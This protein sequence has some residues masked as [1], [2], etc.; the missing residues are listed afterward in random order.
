[1]LYPKKCQ[2]GF[3][4][5]RLNGRLIHLTTI[6]TEPKVLWEFGLQKLKTCSFYHENLF[7]QKVK[8]ISTQV[9]NNFFSASDIMEAVRGCFVL[10]YECYLTTI[11]VG[12]LLVP[13]NSMFGLSHSASFA[14]QKGPTKGQMK[15]KN[16]HL[17]A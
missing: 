2:L 14:Y 3:T 12:T 11:G 10:W 7:L 16:R 9:L 1:M 15:S 13:F 17:E 6:S 5:C 4:G 8:V